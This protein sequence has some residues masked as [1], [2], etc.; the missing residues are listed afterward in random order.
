MRNA[1]MMHMLFQID[2]ERLLQLDEIYHC[3]SAS[4]I[5]MLQ[6]V[7]NMPRFTTAD[8]CYLIQTYVYHAAFWPHTLPRYNAFYEL[9]QTDR[10]AHKKI[11]SDSCIEF[12]RAEL[13]QLMRKKE[14]AVHVD[15]VKCAD[16]LPG[17]VDEQAYL[18]KLLGYAMTARL[19]H[20]RKK[21]DIIWKKNAIGTIH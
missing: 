9:I 13:D 5:V 18:A 6:A 3:E 4:E 1:A 10:V 17:Q 21:E 7:K 2:R 15:V 8:I 20:Q 19:E 16:Q 14:S 12:M 11:C